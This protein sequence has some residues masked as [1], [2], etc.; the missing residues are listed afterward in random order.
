MF[1]ENAPAIDSHLGRHARSAR[2]WNARRRH[3]LETFDWEFANDSARFDGDILGGDRLGQ[4]R[5][6]HPH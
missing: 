6:K 5:G 1:L 4:Y 2:E 3:S